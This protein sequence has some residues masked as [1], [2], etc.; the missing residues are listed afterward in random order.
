MHGRCVGEH[1]AVK[2]HM[3]GLPQVIEFLAQPFGKFG[4]NV[5]MLN[6]AIHPMINRHGE[7]QLAQ[8]G[9]HGAG[10]VGI[11]QLAGNLAPIR[12]NGTMDLAQG[13]RGGGHLIKRREPRLP[14]RPQFALHP[15]ADEIAA[16]WWR[17][18]LQLR[19]LVGIFRWQRIR[20]SGQ[21][22]RHL[23]QRAFQ[24]AEDDLEVLGMPGTIG[25]DPERAFPD[26]PCGD[27]ANRA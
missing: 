25:F 13:R 24:S 8:I 3:R 10:H 7:L 21:E 12:Q 22:L 18:G 20:H 5:V 2:P 27:P 17:V 11:L 1:G 26:H 16:H 9:I 4:I 14:I 15:A 19:Q 23:H 6:G